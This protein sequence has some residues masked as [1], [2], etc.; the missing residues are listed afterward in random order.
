MPSRVY[1][2]VLCCGDTVTD[3]HLGRCELLNL[4]HAGLGTEQ[5]SLA[6]AGGSGGGEGVLVTG[7]APSQK[8]PSELAV[9]AAKC[10]ESLQLPNVEFE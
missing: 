5:A 9:P 7:S 4:K 10:R 1:R 6:R 2:S 8:K 3:F